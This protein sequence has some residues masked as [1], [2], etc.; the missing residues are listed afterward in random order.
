[1]EDYFD[2]FFPL[3]IDFTASKT[4]N[5]QLL[6]KLNDIAVEKE[7]ILGDAMLLS[8]RLITLIELRGMRGARVTLGA[9]VMTGVFGYCAVTMGMEPR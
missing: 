7:W 4:L 8:L 5:G 3:C 9:V 2:T 6:T 1:M